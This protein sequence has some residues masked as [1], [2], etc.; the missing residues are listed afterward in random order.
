MKN[1]MTLK[2]RF[3]EFYD[4]HCEVIVYTILVLLVL[5]FSAI[6][7]LNVSF[8]NSDAV[9]TAIGYEGVTVEYRDRK[10]VLRSDFMETS[11]QYSIGDKITVHVDEWKY[12][13]QKRMYLSDEDK[14]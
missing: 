11:N 14:E 9:V 4:E 10:G 7:S 2:D 8:Y 12:R 5:I 13:A 6:F 3:G 1:K